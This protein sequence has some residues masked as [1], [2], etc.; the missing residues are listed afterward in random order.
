[1]SRLQKL[2]ER[3]KKV[4]AD[5]TWEELVSLLRG[6]GYIKISSGK[7]SGSRQKFINEKKEILS[8]HKPHPGNIVKKYVIQ[9][10]LE[11]LKDRGLEL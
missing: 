6:L 10:I 1:M 3:F 9:Q 2:I 5:L 4:P 8:I 7:T 11:S